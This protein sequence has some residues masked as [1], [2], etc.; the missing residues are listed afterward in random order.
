MGNVEEVDEVQAIVIKEMHT[1]L[2]K[3]KK[4]VIVQ[5]MQRVEQKGDSVYIEYTHIR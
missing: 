1:T 3:P 2:C 5:I 4:S